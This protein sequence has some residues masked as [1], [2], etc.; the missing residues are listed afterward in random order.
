MINN[1]TATELP[2]D[3]DHFISV[4]DNTPAQ[5]YPY[6]HWLIDDLLPADMINHLLALPFEPSDLHYDVGSREEHNPSRQYITPEA[7]ANFPVCK[8]LTDIFQSPDVIRKFEAMGDMSLKD[9]LLRV[10]YTVDTKGF[11][12]QPHTDIGVKTFTMLL[13]LSKGDATKDWGTDIYE[14]ANTHAATV[15]FKSNSA[16]MFIP[17]QNTWHG[18]EPRKINGVRK[19]LII[20]YVTQD[21]R[22]RQELV[23][24]TNTVI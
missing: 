13:Y 9:T 1:A 3:V 22:N 7:V 23:H 14:D 15:P 20:N 21:W 10:E 11:W 16:L 5:Q 12:L 2:S 6:K 19:S 17:A 18:F 8:R 24:P 4:L